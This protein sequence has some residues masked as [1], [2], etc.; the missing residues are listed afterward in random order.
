MEAPDKV[1][2]ILRVGDSD[3]YALLDLGANLSF[4]TLFFTYKFHACTKVLHEPNKVSNPMGESIVAQRV[5]RGCP[6]SV[7]HKVI[8]CDLVELPM[9][10]FDVI[11]GMDWFH[12]SYASIDYRIVRSNSNSLMMQS[13]N[14]RVV[15]LH[16]RVNSFI[17]SRSVR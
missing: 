5:Y 9:V 4:V 8:P 17:L 12:T 13:L 14:E 10:D 3:A 6:I 11:L 1:T 16:V 2:G 7:L 15:S